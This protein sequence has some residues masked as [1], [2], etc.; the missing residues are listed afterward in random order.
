MAMAVTE[1]TAETASTSNTNSYAMGAAG[2]PANGELLV[3]AVVASGTVAAGTMTGGGWTWT[4]L[5]SFTKNSG[6]DTIYIF[7]APATGTTSTT[8]TFDCTGDNA[9]GC[10]IA[11][12]RL[13]GLY[14]QNAP[15]I[16]QMK[17]NTGTSTNPSV[18]MDMAILTGNG[19]LAI[20]ANGTNSA[21][22]WS[23]TSYVEMAEAA[24][25]TPPN[26]LTWQ[27]RL[28]GETGTTISMT[29]SNT[30]AWGMIVIEFWE[31]AAGLAALSA[32]TQNQY[33]PTLPPAGMGVF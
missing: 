33:C 16:R 30:T 1:L 10:I 13:T 31:A 25:N 18:T 17:T 19:V 27:H 21:T 14:G 8:P 24:Y 29:N 20:A 5:T 15:F 22:Q 32:M 2:T 26:S 12:G 23:M 28:S 9:T 7:T 4:R 3:A 6:A 11:C